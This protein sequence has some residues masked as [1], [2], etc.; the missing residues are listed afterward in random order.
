[1]STVG[2]KNSKPLTMSAARR[3]TKFTNGDA[4]VLRGGHGVLSATLGSRKELSAV[5]LGPME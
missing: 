4:L 5:H 2:Q 3:K 1:M